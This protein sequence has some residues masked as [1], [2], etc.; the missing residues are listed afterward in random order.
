MQ[1]KT[2]G[3]STVNPS[4]SASRL[5]PF[6]PVVE[7]HFVVQLHSPGHLCS[8]GLC[9]ALKISHRIRKIC[10]VKLSIDHQPYVCYNIK[11]CSCMMRG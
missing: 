7:M 8:G 6:L 2:I 10:D 5:Q 1:N 11:I 4:D 3:R 9:I